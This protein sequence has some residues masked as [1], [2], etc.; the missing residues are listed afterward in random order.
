MN[1]LKHRKAEARLR[2][3]NPDGTPAANCPVRADQVSHQ[4]LFGCGTF[5]TVALMKTVDEQRKAFFTGADGK[6]AGLVQLRHAALL[7]GTV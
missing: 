1:A 6:M 3:L 7:L 4:F 2:L 5:D